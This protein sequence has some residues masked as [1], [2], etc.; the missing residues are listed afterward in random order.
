MRDSANRLPFVLARSMRVYKSPDLQY[1]MTTHKSFSCSVAKRD[2]QRASTTVTS[3]LTTKDMEYFNSFQSFNRKF[4]RATLVEFKFFVLLP[5]SS[6]QRKR[7]KAHLLIEKV[8]TVW[9]NVG[10][11]KR[12]QQ[13]RLQHS[14]PPNYSA[15]Y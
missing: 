5:M 13:R 3:R 10:M 8:I 11:T 4:L 15:V 14:Q 7:F 2:A 12:C 1:D 6:I 9:H